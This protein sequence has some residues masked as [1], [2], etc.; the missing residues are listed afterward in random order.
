MHKIYIKT[1][2]IWVDFT[3]ISTLISLCYCLTNQFGNRDESVC[4]EN[5]YF[6]HL[7]SKNDI[8]IQY[9]SKTG[10]FLSQIKYHFPDHL[11]QIIIKLGEEGRQAHKGHWILLAPC[12]R[13][14]KF[15]SSL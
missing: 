13:R 9:D 2:T 14:L 4:I 3:K 10:Q 7:T 8:R 5:L 1:Q 15:I 12:N 6:S 11:L